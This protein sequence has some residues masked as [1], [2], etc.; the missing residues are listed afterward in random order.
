L[1]ALSA[2]RK[3]SGRKFLPQYAAEFFA[4]HSSA[5]IP[6]ATAAIFPP[7]RVNSA[8]Y[9]IEPGAQLHMPPSSR[10]LST[11]MLPPGQHISGQ[12]TRAHGC[13]DLAL[14]PPSAFQRQVAAGHKGLGHVATSVATLAFVAWLQQSLQPPPCR[15][16][17][18]CALPRPVSKRRTATISRRMLI[19]R[20]TWPP[21]AGGRADWSLVTISL[22][23]SL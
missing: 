1:S 19:F 20:L 12:R 18:P 21:F 16:N 23:S 7:A 15:R 4:E 13:N 11:H 17:W 22:S 2:A 10:S 8:Q 14:K 6:A 3:H 5:R 9:V